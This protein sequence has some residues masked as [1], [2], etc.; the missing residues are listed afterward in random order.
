MLRGCALSK[1]KTLCFFPCKHVTNGV[2]FVW[3]HVYPEPARVSLHRMG[4]FCTMWTY[5][6]KLGAGG[7][8]VS[9]QYI[10]GTHL[11]SCLPS[12]AELIHRT[13]KQSDFL[14]GDITIHQVSF[15]IQATKM[16]KWYNLQCVRKRAERLLCSA[17]KKKAAW[18]Q[19]DLIS[20]ISR[21][22]KQCLVN[23]RHYKNR[24]NAKVVTECRIMF[25]HIY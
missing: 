24:L 15:I 19:M 16:M 5:P 25:H 12:C 17:D 23:Y 4:L 10:Q 18:N 8:S 22:E 7:F 3:R 9:V 13:R 2:L 11:H 21:P 1:F 20:L 14:L 6:A